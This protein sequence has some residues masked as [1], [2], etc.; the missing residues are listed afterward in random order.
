MA[1]AEMAPRLAAA[2]DAWIR[3]DLE[4]DSRRRALV[5]Q[6]LRLERLVA[7]RELQLIRSGARNVAV[8]DARYMQKRV[9]KLRAAESALAAVRAG[10]RALERER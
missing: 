6:R 1:L 2:R 9:A 4:R 7:H 10:L 5:A 8:R 3:W